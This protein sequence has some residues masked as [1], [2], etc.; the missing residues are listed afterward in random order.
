MKGIPPQRAER[1]A[2]EHICRTLQLFAFNRTHLRLEDL[3]H[4]L[5]AHDGRRG[6][7]DVPK[8]QGSILTRE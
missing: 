3:R 1:S 7:R 8:S 4:S 2:A 6:Q 5:S